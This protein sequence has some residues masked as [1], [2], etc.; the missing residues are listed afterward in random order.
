MS[1]YPDE[2]GATPKR[3][4]WEETWQAEQAGSYPG[5]YPRPRRGHSL[6]KM[7]M[8]EEDCVTNGIPLAKSACDP[9]TYIVLFG[10][11]DNDGNLTHI[12]KTYNVD[13]D[14]DGSLIFTTY[15]EKPV[16]PCFDEDNIYF[17]DAD[18]VNCDQ[19]STN[20][21]VAF[22]YND[23]WAYKVYPHKT[24]EEAE[25]GEGGV[26]DK[27]FCLGCST[28]SWSSECTKCTDCHR[29]WDSPCIGSGWVLWHPGGREGGC[30]IQLG[31]E[32]C[33][34]PS[35]R[36]EHTAV[37][38]DDGS[39]Y[40]YGGFSQRCADFCDDM[41]YFDIFLK[42][43]RQLFDAG[44][45]GRLYE[46]TPDGTIMPYPN[47][48]IDDAANPN[49]G[50]GKRWKHSMAGSESV[51][52]Y[53]K[54]LLD[55]VTCDPLL[56]AETCLYFQNRDDCLFLLSADTCDYIITLS[57][58]GVIYLQQMAVFGGHRLWHGF[59][60]ENE[61]SN[62]WGFA[63]S[64][65]FGGYMNDFWLY[66]KILDF[67]TQPSSTFKA[68]EGFWRQFQLHE[69]CSIP[70]AAC[71]WPGRRAGHSSVF[72]NRRNRVW[73]F[74]GYRTY[75]PYLKTDGQGSGL[76][77]TSL[78][79]GGF[80][81]YPE[82]DYYLKDLWYFD[83]LSGL[84][85]E[86]KTIKVKI[87]RLTAFTPGLPLDPDKKFTLIFRYF[88]HVD[89]TLLSVDA[90]R[91]ISITSTALEVKEA[92]EELDSIGSISVVRSGYGN[93]KYPYGFSWSIYFQGNAD[94][95]GDLSAQ[96]GAEYG[97][98]AVKNVTESY[99]GTGILR[100]IEDNK[101]M[102][103]E[104]AMMDDYEGSLLTRLNPGDEIIM[105]N[106]SKLPEPVRT[107]T[108]YTKTVTSVEERF[109]YFSKEEWDICG[110]SHDTKI[111]LFAKT[112][113]VVSVEEEE[114][115]QP[116][117]RTE[118]VLMMKKD[119]IYKVWERLGSNIDDLKGEQTGDEAGTSIS[120]SSDGTII[121]I[122]APGYN[123]DRGTVRVYTSPSGGAW[124][125]H[126]SNIIGT[127]AVNSVTGIT[128]DKAGT[129][130]S[131]SS[132]GQT[133]CV[134]APGHDY[135]KGA[136]RI[137]RSSEG[138]WSQLGND[139]DGAS[140]G[141]KFGTSVSMSTEATAGD[142]VAVGIPGHN[143]NQGKVKVYRFSGGA[144]VQRGGDIVGLTGDQHGHSVS[145]SSDSNTV[146]VG[147]PGH[148]SSL[149]TVRVY[150]YGTSWVQ[151][152]GANDLNGV[153]ETG[154]SSVDQAGYSV[155]LSGD[156]NIVAVGAPGRSLQTGTVRV[157]EYN[158]I[159]DVWSQLGQ[160]IAGDCNGDT[161]D[162][163]GQQSGYSVD[164]TSDGNTVAIG[165]IGND[166]EATNGG[167]VRVYEYDG[168][169]W[170]KVCADHYTCMSDLYGES[171]SDQIGT[172][173]SI[174]GSGTDIKIA[175]GASSN[176]PG[177]AGVFNFTSFTNN[178]IDRQEVLD[179]LIMHGG[180][181]NNYAF[182]DM[183]YFDIVTK[184]WLEKDTFIYPDY[185]D[186]CTDDFDYIDAIENDPNIPA[187]EK[188]IKQHWAKD[189]VRS[190]RFPFEPKSF[191]PDIRDSSEGGDPNGYYSGQDHYWPDTRYGAYWK[192]QEKGFR[193]EALDLMNSDFENGYMQWNR[194]PVWELYKDDALTEYGTDNVLAPFGTPMAV[195]GYS[196]T[197]PDQYVRS[198]KFP[199]NATRDQ[200][201][202]SFIYGMNSSHE[203]TFYE[204]C[205]SVYAEPTRG[206]IID[207]E[208]GRAMYPVTIA[209]P[210][211]QRPGW[212][213]C[214]DNIN[215]N[216]KPGLTY[217]KPT[218]RFS[219][220]AVYI[221]ETFEIF[222][223]GGM[224]YDQEYQPNIETTYPMQVKDD[225]WLFHF[226][227]CINNCSNNRDN[228][229][230]IRGNC[231]Y[232]YCIC[233]YGYYGV[234]CSNT[235]CP[236]TACYYD[237]LSHEQICQHGC[238]SSWNHTDSD[239]YQ[240]DVAKVPCTRE[241]PGEENGVCDGHGN[242]MCAPPF[243][244]S[245]CAVKDCKNNCSFNGWC[246]VE[247]PVSRCMCSPGYYGEI[248]QFQE[249]LNN[250]SWPN[251]NCN[252]NNGQ[253]SCEM[254]YSPYENYKDFKRWG[255][256]DCSYLHAYAAAPN[257]LKNH[258]FTVLLMIIITLF[259]I[260]SDIDFMTI[261]HENQ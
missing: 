82:Y 184:R 223:F 2:A 60:I 104:V 43:W 61:Q 33:T 197:G 77:V 40:V 172:S 249:C 110:H 239:Y 193:E 226:D 220:A 84:W 240:Q 89:A 3:N 209:V 14:G 24:R 180:Y 167:K 211:R 246:S 38:Y 188:C 135:N 254:M 200:L 127:D 190:S 224:A 45:L 6:L 147:S 7:T 202:K 15:D 8:R 129:S 132:D 128:G 159:L 144:W 194:R 213:G 120:L 54:T 206:T 177:T 108:E 96:F 203:A 214:R 234:D 186:G 39:M 20:V 237:D 175:Y 176:G 261:K 70:G 146:A 154:S 10:G 168:C 126:G 72:D 51:Q 208:F 162:A 62:D 46:Q 125:Q 26:S 5:P 69:S 231:M 163:T 107:G 219:H 79:I 48:P 192:L 227:H 80:V 221:D 66:T 21:P 47:V 115:I 161:C 257:V 130:V 35:E 157:Y 103:C 230:L 55:P 178:T 105:A 204:R 218:A 196:G 116:P 216:G 93:F 44:K 166:D 41:W 112:K 235:S 32:V 169:T 236:G 131:L 36:F 75:Y 151:I 243:I 17:T 97:C 52:I 238:Q 11:R 201:L 119:A 191:L 160:N 205:T 137:Y 71:V 250:C 87:I 99:I 136:V 53:S 100:I 141:D 248:C 102:G 251:G 134:G 16:D 65:P 12:P 232:G 138:G 182:D 101:E 228:D 18:K 109:V 233:N 165:S 145:L 222:L 124:K 181:A 150:R 212:D 171:V 58:C 28:T 30:V 179:T 198:Y 241:Y 149:G 94:Y 185:T 139:I 92:L 256:E 215:P 121:A 122:G 22:I 252:I 164:L 199:V 34:V 158:Q 29:A 123:G 9:G 111:N 117:P 90:T 244:G 242:T 42:G 210:R 76:G 91:C 207:G 247:F 255:G 183:W 133:V 27:D 156:G 13:K 253:C 258:F 85:T 229:G 86:V 114:D 64:R 83:I 259:L 88:H 95:L 4:S 106:M 217:K 68:G 113:I 245:D 25:I 98:T 19:K 174:Q 50:P 170:K 81:P 67:D 155:S 142:T 49:A 153:L 56:G 78:G 140:A 63:D 23:V 195:D 260:V 189:L 1:D 74:G 37:A 173:V 143:S 59:N 148:S 225:M 187:D 73:I 118:M 152:G 57:D 31:I